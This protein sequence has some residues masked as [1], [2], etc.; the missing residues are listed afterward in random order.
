MKITKLPLFL[1][2]AL[3][4]ICANVSAEDD[5]EEIPFDEA[6]LFFELNDTDGD[7]GI[8]GKV[9][10]DEW[11]YLEIEDP[12]ERDM[13]RIWIRGRLRRQGLTELFFES[14]EPPFDELD[15][16]DFF[17]RFPEGTYEIE[18]YTLDGEER[19][20]EVY[21][22]H[23]IPEAPQKLTVNYQAAP[24]DCDE[25]QPPVVSAPVTLRWDS[26]DSAH[27]ELGSHRGGGLESLGIE[28]IYYEVVAEIDDTDY[29]ETVI[30]P[31]ETSEVTLSPAIIGLVDEAE[32][33]EFKFEILVRTD[34]GHG[35]PGN[36]SA[37]ESCFVLE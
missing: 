22:S 33:R 14:A 7:L 35:N 27:E 2:A 3:I 4:G 23:I 8:H 21:L 32:D 34:N 36:K 10:G 30:V 20:S 18:G 1:V 11:K 24:E 37:L 28:V 13:A 16:D 25:Q 6:R 12:F 9:D 26:V 29:K 19:E 31:A 17:A 15:P 5:D